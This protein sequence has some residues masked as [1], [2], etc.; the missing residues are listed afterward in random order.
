MIYVSKQ[1]R[2]LIS[3]G[4]RRVKTSEIRAYNV[5]LAIVQ[6]AS[7]TKRSVG[8]MRSGSSLLDK[9]VFFSFVTLSLILLLMQAATQTAFANSNP[10]SVHVYHFSTLAPD[11]DVQLQWPLNNSY[12]MSIDL[13]VNASPE[14]NT[15]IF[16][17]HQFS[18]MN[19][20]WGYIGFGIGGTVKVATIAVLD[21]VGGSTSN[22]TGGCNVG[23]PFLKTGTGYQCFII[24]DWKLGFNY[25]LQFSRLSD[26]NGSEQWQGTM[27]DYSTNSDTTIGTIVVAP[28]YAQ[29]GSTSST[30]DEYSTA[31]SCDTPASSVTFS[32]P[33]AMNAA[34]NHAPV[35]AT[36]TYG[37]STCQDSNI[38]YLG[39]GAYQADAGQNVARNTPAQTS[40]WAQE[41]SLVS[42]NSATTTT[43]PPAST[44][45]SS[46]G[47]SAITTQTTAQSMSSH[48]TSS[49]VTTTMVTT[50]STVVTM[51]AAVPGIPGFPW[52]SIVAGLV[53]GFAL[54]AM[55]RRRREQSR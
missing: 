51:P 37:N 19:G 9:R 10:A 22:P 23:V 39:G 11:S 4:L 38:Q 32:Y 2:N 25:R 1:L 18:F 49:A 21:A 17:G 54:L 27:H 26:N 34:G 41:P 16:W 42:Q 50:P 31:A 35:K 30:W 5:G 15:S 44:Q 43:S 46:T 12:S 6:M 52:E 24:Y 33:Y 55:I 20:E 8:T 40:L 28:D 7:R 36:A 13:K 14:N 3:F 53:V 45:S 47:I 29:L 48:S